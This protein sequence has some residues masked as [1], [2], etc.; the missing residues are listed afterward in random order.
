MVW[1]CAG[2]Q[3]F[4]SKNVCMGKYSV[5]AEESVDESCSEKEPRLA[6]RVFSI[7]A[8]NPMGF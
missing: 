2:F 7:T 4:N 1:L 8:W 3:V 6:K 5:S